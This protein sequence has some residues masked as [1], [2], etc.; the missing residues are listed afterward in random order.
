V[1]LSIETERLRI[2]P[3]GPEHAQE[4]FEGLSDPELYVYMP[5]EAPR[6]VAALVA[7]FGRQADKPQWLVRELDGGRPVATLQAT[8]ED[9]VHHMA[10]TVFRPYWGRG[11]ATEAL[12]A[13]IDEL[14]HADGAQWFTATVDE[15]NAASRRVMEKCGFAIVG[16][17]TLVDERSPTPIVDLDYGLAWAPR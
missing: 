16:R 6:D 7:Q 17:R 3:L 9:G 15:R 2:E 5:N 8:I 12:R 14:A 1:T 11:Y 4:L 10:Y 13:L